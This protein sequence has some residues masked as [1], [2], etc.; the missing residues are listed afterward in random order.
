MRL[1][2][3]EP[4]LPAFDC[5]LEL[6]LELLPLL[7]LPE[8]L[9][10]LPLLRLPEALELLPLLRLPE[11]RERSLRCWRLLLADPLRVL[12]RLADCL[13]R[14]EPLFEDFFA[15]F[16]DPRFEDRVARCRLDPRELL[17]LVAFFFVAE[18]GLRSA[19][20]VLD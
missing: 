12:L 5:R 16:D 7:R 4:D 14:E 8:A 10:L 19:F 15:T 6:V 3:P 11:A 17:L 18:E 13:T 1:A 2:F 9:E 20:S